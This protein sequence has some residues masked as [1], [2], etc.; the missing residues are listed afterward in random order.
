MTQREQDYFTHLTTSN[1][2]DIG[3]TNNPGPALTQ[4]ICERRMTAE[5]MEDFELRFADYIKRQE[6]MDYNFNLQNENQ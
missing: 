5:E 3:K 1:P 4:R 2:D 6:E